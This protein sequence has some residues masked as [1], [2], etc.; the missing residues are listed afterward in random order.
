MASFEKNGNSIRF[1]SCEAPSGR[2]SLERRN[3]VDWLL[4]EYRKDGQ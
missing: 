3:L 2:K 4:K 1:V